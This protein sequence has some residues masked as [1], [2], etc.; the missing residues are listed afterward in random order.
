MR[1]A[2]NTAYRR[3]NETLQ[4]NYQRLFKSQEQLSSGLRVQRP[5]DDPASAVRIVSLRQ[6]LSRNEAS[7]QAASRGGDV[8]N[9]GAARLGDAASL[10]S[11]ARAL[12]VQAQNGTL[13]E[14]DREVIGQQ[15][16]SLRDQLVS[17]GN[18]QQGGRYLFS[19][20]ATAEAAF[21]EVAHGDS[22]R[23]VYTG[24]DLTQKFDLGNGIKMGINVP[25]EV[26]FGGVT[27]T[28]ISLSGD[29]GLTLGTT[30]NQGST[31][32]EILIEHTATSLS[33]EMSAAGITLG[34]SQD[35]LIGSAQLIVDPVAGT[36]GFQGG[37]AVALPDPTSPDALDFKLKHPGGGVVHLDL[38]AYN[39]QAVD[40]AVVG[41]AQ[42]SIDGGASTAVDFT[43]TD[44]RLE[45]AET[46][47]VIHLDTTELRKAGSELAVFEG[48]TNVI[49]LLQIT[50]DSLTKQDEIG[51]P[52]LNDRLA[53]LSNSLERGRNTMLSSQ[54][55]LGGRG[56][57]VEDIDSDLKNLRVRV[58]EML[59][60]EQDADIAEVA[61]ELQQTQVALQ[62]TQAAAARL[63][64]RTL[65]DFLV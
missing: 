20:S 63:L 21:V 39:G 25:G 29:T 62:A 65:L 17:L 16:Y 59:S 41:Q 23:A 5:S 12:V 47:S 6:R 46:G 1:I 4:S 49:D 3:L 35:T 24:D 45:N 26:A 33:P 60:E 58:A 7:Q 48:S 9:A 37:E 30:A 34:S 54:A 18:S 50:A 2:S 61:L 31:F 14:E 52:A 22:K 19:G 51:L 57:R 32:E 13:S 27:P 64:P 28:G 10:L 40:S 44:L 56:K 43:E 38:D 53:S 15:L 8:I 42:V 11:E 55:T 36:I